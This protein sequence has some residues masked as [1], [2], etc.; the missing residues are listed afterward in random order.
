M[1]KRGGVGHKKRGEDAGCEKQVWG[2]GKI[3]SEPGGAH[4]ELD[5]K[6]GDTPRGR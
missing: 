5:E 4:I 6:R 2:P 1:G 3:G